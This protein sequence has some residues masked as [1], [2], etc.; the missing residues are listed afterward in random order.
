MQKKISALQNKKSPYIGFRPVPP[1]GRFAIV[2]DAGRDAVDAE[3]LPTSSTKADG[4]VVWAWRL[5]AGVKLLGVM[6]GRRRRQTSPISGAS[7]K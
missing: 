5:D 7:T 2:T 1:K 3:V 6:P 4:E